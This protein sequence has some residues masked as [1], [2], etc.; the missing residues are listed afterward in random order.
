MTKRFVK[1]IVTAIVTAIILTGCA[2]K[3]PTVTT[4]TVDVTTFTVIDENEPTITETS[5]NEDGTTT[6]IT[7]T[8]DGTLVSIATTTTEATTQETEKETT[9]TSKETTATPTAAPTETVKPTTEPTKVTTPEPTATTKPEPT[10]TTKPTETPKPTE[11]TT[12]PTTQP[13]TKPSEPTKEP[14][15]KPSEPT[16][17][18][19]E[20]T[21]KPTTPAPTT[22]EPTTPAPE[23]KY[24]VVV[25]GYNIAGAGTTT[26]TGTYKAG[27]K[28]TL[29]FV[30]NDGYEFNKAEILHGNDYVETTNSTYTFT[31]NG[32]VYIN[33]YFKKVQAPTQPAEPDYRTG[34]VKISYSINGEGGGHT[35]VKE[36]YNV[37]VCC[38]SGPNS[39]P[40]AY[41]VIESAK[42]DEILAFL[43]SE[44]YSSYNATCIALD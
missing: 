7:K 29:K 41:Q 34:T 32:D 39:D 36:F 5:K 13:T 37:P 14:T 43:M 40:R 21:T 28:V 3:A 23:V 26:G 27:T 6:I 8:T 35:H 12:K 16:T 1:T 15:T 42:Y 33:V 30:A 18:P 25:D 24:E 4:E 2:T 31:I 20:P 38:F 9:A 22:P 19:T 44:G 10:E 17:K 11:P